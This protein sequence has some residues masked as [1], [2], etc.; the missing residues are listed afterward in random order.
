MRSSSV[1]SPSK[2]SG[3]CQLKAASSRCGAERCLRVSAAVCGMACSRGLRFVG[4][5]R[6][7][8]RTGIHPV[9]SGA[10]LVAD[11][12]VAFSCPRSSAGFKRLAG[13]AVGA[14]R[15]FLRRSSLRDPDILLLDQAAPLPHVVGEHGAQL[16][17]G[18]APDLHAEGLEL[19]LDVGVASACLMAASILSTIAFG[20]PAGANAPIQVATS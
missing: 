14:G 11:A 16:R 12:A 19:G 5:T 7:L 2:S 17:A 20:V 6:V 1:S 15:E 18:A 8:R 9:T 4:L 10:G 3:S 13:R